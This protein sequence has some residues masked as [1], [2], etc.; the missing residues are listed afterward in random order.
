MTKRKK[1]TI[2]CVGTGIGVTLVLVIIMLIVG[3]LGL[4]SCDGN[5]TTHTYHFSV[6]GENGNITT[7]HDATS[8]L[9]RWSDKKRHVDPVEF[10]ATPNDGYQVKEWKLDGEIV[11]DNKSNT[12]TA[13]YIIHEELDIYIT[14]EF[15]LIV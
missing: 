9:N 13:S 11:K 4:I 1:I 14:V 10:I 7:E 6:V 2:G 12:F 5:T 3:S 8:P 15:E